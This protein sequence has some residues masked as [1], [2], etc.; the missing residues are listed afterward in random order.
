[1]NSKLLE[2]S[3]AARKRTLLPLFNFRP[4]HFFRSIIDED[5]HKFVNKQ[6]SYFATTAY[7]DLPHILVAWIKFDFIAMTLLRLLPRTF[8]SFP[9][10]HLI[11]RLRPCHDSSF[12]PR[13]LGILSALL[14]TALL[15]QA[16]S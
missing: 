16:H 10:I 4:I 3:S 7:K 14:H 2:P 11:S 5:V 12:P 1:M 8:V 13:R 15:L 9:D 6:N